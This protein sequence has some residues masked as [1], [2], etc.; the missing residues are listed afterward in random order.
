LIRVLLYADDLVLLADSV[1]D[2]QAMLDVLHEFCCFNAMSVNIKE[3]EE[4]VFNAL[5]SKQNSDKILLSI[6]QS[7]VYLGLCFDSTHNVEKS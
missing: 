4:V 5:H 3:S 1:H 2:L 7:L 6:A